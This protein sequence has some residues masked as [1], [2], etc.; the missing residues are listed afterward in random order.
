MAAGF[1]IAFALAVTVVTV[2]GA[3]DRGTV[4][5]DHD[6]AVML[7]EDAYAERARGAIDYAVG[8]L[9]DPAG[10]FF[11]SEAESADAGSAGPG[12]SGSSDEAPRDARRIDRIFVTASNARMVRTLLRAADVLRANLPRGTVTTNGPLSL[13]PYFLRLSVDG[14]ADA[15]TSYTISDHDAGVPTVSAIPEDMMEKAK[16]KRL[17]YTSVLEMIAE[18]FHASPSLLKRLN[19]SAK[20]GA[21]GRSRPW[22]RPNQRARRTSWAWWRPC[23]RSSP[24][25]A[26]AWRLRASR[27]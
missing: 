17:E 25:R 1:L 8:V 2:F 10:G 22:P 7:D 16:L 5:A 21:R 20:F 9:G 27:I 18:R 23:A 14:N 19:P 26:R 15:P 11:E 12:E 13:D 3:G 24:K 6:A 4:L